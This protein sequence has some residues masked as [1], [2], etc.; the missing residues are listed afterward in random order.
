MSDSAKANVMANEDEAGSR[1]RKP[2]HKPTVRHERVFEVRALTCGKV[3]T[4][5]AQCHYQRKTS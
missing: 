2:Y 5:E 3:N 1:P 4:T